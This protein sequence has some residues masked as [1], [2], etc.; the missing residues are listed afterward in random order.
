MSVSP[1]PDPELDL[2]VRDCNAANAITDHL[3]RTLAAQQARRRA[4]GR[5]SIRWGLGGLGAGIVMIVI[6]GDGDLR[7]QLLAWIATTCGALSLVRGLIRV[8][9]RNP[10][11]V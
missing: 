9:S 7:M 1:S 5:A 10:L 11:R 4:S 2:I 6:A 3:E 8:L